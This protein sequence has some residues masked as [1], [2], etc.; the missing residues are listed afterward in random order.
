[1]DEWFI[2]MDNPEENLARFDPKDNITRNPDGSWKMT[3][4]QVRMNVFT[5]DGYR[6][7]MITTY[8]A[9]ELH[10]K[11]YMQ[12]PNDWKNVEI[13]GYIK[14]ND[15]G[16]GDD[17][18]AWYARGGFH[19]NNAGDGGS[20][21]EGTCYK[22]DLYFNGDTRIA[23]EQWHNTGYAYTPTKDAQRGS[24][25]GKW[26]GF[27]TVIYNAADNR[28]VH[29]E[30]YADWEDNNT[31]V[32]IDEKFDNG[33]FGNEG[34]HCSGPADQPVTWGGPV[35]TFRWDTAEDVDFKNL[36]VREIQPPQ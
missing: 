9:D 22:G 34:D 7:N 1:G 10:T 20:G 33:G 30:L 25:V 14:V 12:S 17:N 19:G 29:V 27:K 36:S 8:D 24:I 21:C 11:G 26:V 13:T 28:G 35:A 32:K 18:F 23:K 3:E 4:T 6:Q 2:N 16:G 31:W 5:T 15:D